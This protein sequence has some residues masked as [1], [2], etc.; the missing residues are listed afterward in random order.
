MKREF[1]QTAEDGDESAYLPSLVLP[2]LSV[3]LPLNCVAP[4]SLVGWATMHNIQS[5]K[6]LGSWLTCFCSNTSIPEDYIELHPP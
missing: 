2:Y 5:V 1:L 3:R 6:H 4:A